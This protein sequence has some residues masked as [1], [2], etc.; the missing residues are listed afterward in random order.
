VLYD[1]PWSCWS[2]RPPTTWPGHLTWHGIGEFAVLFTLVWIA[3]ANGSLRH[4]LPCH[5]DAHARNTFP[6]RILILV[7]MGGCI[8]QADGAREAAVAAAIAAMV[9]LVDHAHDGRTTAATAW[10]A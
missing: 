9:S 5:D 7:A 4:E 6:L 8:P 1:L 10:I 2:P 3:W